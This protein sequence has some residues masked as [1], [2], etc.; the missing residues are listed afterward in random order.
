MRLIAGIAL[1]NDAVRSLRGDQAAEPA[2]LYVLAAS[3]GLLLVVGLW[4]PIAGVL[5]AV[6]EVWKA[7]SAS[8]DP[9]AKI[10]LGTLGL[11]LAL[12]GPG[13][14]SIDARIF[15]WKRIDIPTH[16]ELGTQKGR[17]NSP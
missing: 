8:G 12:L 15:G 6:F 3:A 7:F 17:Q 13:V 11:A 10:L 16:K 5:V 9:F 14:W 4:T 2:I 1:I